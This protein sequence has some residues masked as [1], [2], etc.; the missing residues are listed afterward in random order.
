MFVC[1]RKSNHDSSKYNL[2]GRNFGIQYE[3][4]SVFVLYFL[5]TYLLTYSAQAVQ[6]HRRI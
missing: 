1:L 5:L 6:M 3:I 2:S 4:R